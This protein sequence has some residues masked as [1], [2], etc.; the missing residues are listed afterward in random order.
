MHLCTAVCPGDW[1]NAGITG[2]AFH[3][4]GLMRPTDVKLPAFVNSKQLL[5]F[6]AVAV[7]EILN[8]GTE[9]LKKISK[10]S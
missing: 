9:S 4:S 7:K 1:C 5:L 3:I 6:L 2:N 10:G 8:C